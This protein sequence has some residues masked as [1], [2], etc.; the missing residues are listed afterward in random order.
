MATPLVR[1]VTRIFAPEVAA[2]AFRQRLLADAFASAGC[3]VEVLTTTPPAGTQPPEDGP[4][5]VSR[6]PARRDAN[7]NIR[8]YLHY[9]SYDLPLAIRLLGRRPADL[10]IAEPPPTT[11]VVMRVV[12]AL[13]RRPYVW[14]AADIWSEAAGAA[15]APPFV[16]RVL[17]GVERWVLG[18]ATLVLAISDGGADKLRGFGLDDDRILTVG[19]G[20]DTSVFTPEGP[21]APAPAP[22]FV[23]TGTMSEWQGAG[24]FI[25]ALKLHHDAGGR[26]RIVFVGQGHELPALRRLADELVPGAVDFTGVLSPVE[27]AQWIRGAVAALVSIRPGLGYDFAKPTKIYAA[28]A[29]GVPVVFAGRGAGPALVSS[30]ELGWASDYD[31]RG[32]AA[33]FTQAVDEATGSTKD[34]HARADRLVAW[35]EAHASLRAIASTTSEAVLALLDETRAARSLRDGE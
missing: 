7:G 32:V 20:V 33:A 4:L 22:Y 34:V 26:T 31:D 24:V 16:V 10:Y 18:G 3:E 5:H 23:Y 30:Q 1:V 8:G 27:T 14:Y 12:A 35:T 29:C 9:L 15:G 28:T 21:H 11:G 17:R 19:N 25:R 6:W 13:H 2:A